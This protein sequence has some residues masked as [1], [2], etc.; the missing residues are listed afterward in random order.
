MPKKNKK[1]TYKNTFNVIPVWKNAKITL[2][3]LGGVSFLFILSYYTSLSFYPF[4]IGV[5]LLF[6][7]I[8]FI[9]NKR[10][11]DKW[12]IWTITMM[13]IYVFSALLS[14]SNTFNHS[15]IL[16]IGIIS[17]YFFGIYFSRNFP[18]DHSVYAILF[19]L[20]F[21]LSIEHIIVTIIDIAEF[22]LINP[23][24]ILETIE[25]GF[26]RPVTQ[27]VID[28]SL[29]IGGLGFI[30]FETKD[31][32]LKRFKLAFIFFGIIAFLCSIHYVSRTGVAIMLIALIASVLY[33]WKLLSFR[34]IVFT[35][36]AIGLAGL[37]QRTELFDVYAAREIEGSSIEDLGSR[38][39]KWEWGW[40]SLLDNP[41]GL[42]EI[43]HISY[44]HN[45]WLDFGLK[46]GIIVFFMMVILSLV[47]IIK[48]I[49]IT[50][51][52]HESIAFRFIVMLYS[53]CFFFAA[54]TEAVPDGNQQY[55]FIYFFWCGLINNIV[56]TRNTL[57]KFHYN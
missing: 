36:I 33:Q 57:K 51:N 55:F 32:I 39:P 2:L 3:S 10:V 23:L 37:L 41:F 28:L 25:D 48:S 27:R 13:S 18:G 46:G 53:V 17:Y 29:A 31:F 47:N 21:V 50:T 26:Q 54:F 16:L 34:T 14:D 5:L 7:Y 49:K 30:T 22:G 24:R 40:K 11:Y 9:S 15:F 45:M 52:K 56:S 4:I 8:S 6:G 12:L 38:I 20:M 44:A 35:L 19:M 43:K 1:K 42:N